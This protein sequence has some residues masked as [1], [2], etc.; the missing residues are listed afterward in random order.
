MDPGHHESGL[1]L[2]EET[3]GWDPVGESSEDKRRSGELTG[4]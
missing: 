1:Q 4:L 3:G 2:T